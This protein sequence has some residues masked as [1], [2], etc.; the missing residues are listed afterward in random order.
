MSTLGQFSRA[1]KWVMVLIGLTLAL[2]L[3][4]LGKAIVALQYA[5]RLPNLRM[6]VSLDYFA[7]MGGFWGMVFLACAVGLSHF[8]AWARWST[9]A[10]VTLYQVNVWV[11]HLLFEASDYARQTTP[12][13][14][15]L[16]AVL[17][18]TFWGSLSLPAV[19]RAFEENK[20]EHQSGSAV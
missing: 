5:A 6:T 7:V 15:V 3:A 13:N 11:N 4:N 8:Q 12:R 1:Q 19:R 14:L 16:T 9:L 10:A 2:G 20:E 18:L 17:L